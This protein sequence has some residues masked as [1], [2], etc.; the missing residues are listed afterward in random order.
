LLLL[1]TTYRFE[2]G[3]A[4]AFVV[5]V[6]VAVVDVAVDD[7]EVSSVANTVIGI[8]PI[9]THST[10]ITTAMRFIVFIRLPPYK[11]GNFF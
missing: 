9:S 4:S 11:I 10:I 2:S 5:V 8:S 1:P 3:T 7:C 6:V